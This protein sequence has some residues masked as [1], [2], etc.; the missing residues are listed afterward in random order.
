VRG[1][2]RLAGFGL[3]GLEDAQR[4]ELIAD[5]IRGQLH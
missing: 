3:G 2:A 5:G 1:E 4:I